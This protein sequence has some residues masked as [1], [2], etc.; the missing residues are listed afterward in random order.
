MNRREWEILRKQRRHMSRAD[1]TASTWNCNYNVSL[2]VTRTLL[3]SQSLH[4]L[5]A[6]GPPPIGDEGPAARNPFL[7]WHFAK[8]CGR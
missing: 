3:T 2:V 6:V 1:C 4:Q 5:L 7:R 8:P